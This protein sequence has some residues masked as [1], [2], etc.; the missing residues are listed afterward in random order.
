MLD[1]KAKN[2]AKVLSSHYDKMDCKGV[3]GKAGV[4]QIRAA[5]APL[6]TL[7]DYFN[8][9]SDKSC[10]LLSEDEDDTITACARENEINCYYDNE[11][12]DNDQ[13]SVIGAVF[14]QLM[15]F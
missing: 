9:H 15:R 8:S 12:P 14:K 5:K 10:Q 3:A 7:D 2:T 1:N 4:P 6:K 13:A 11:Y